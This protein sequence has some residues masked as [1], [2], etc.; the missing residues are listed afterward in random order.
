MSRCWLTIPE[1]QNSILKR[2]HLDINKMQGVK[3]SLTGVPCRV[4][5]RSST[6][7][8]CPSSAHSHR[9]LHPSSP[10]N[11][12]TFF[13]SFSPSLSSRPPQQQ[14]QKFL[15][16]IQNTRHGVWSSRPCILCASS[17]SSRKWRIHWRLY[18]VGTSSDLEDD[19]YM[20][21]SDFNVNSNGHTKI[22]DKDQFNQLRVILYPSSSDP[23]IKA[24]N[25]ANSVQEVFD[26]VERCGDQL[27]A[28]QASQA[29]VT[30][31]DLQKVYGRFG[32]DRDNIHGSMLTQFLEKIVSHP[33]FKKLITSLDRLCE[34]L[35]ST[36]VSC[37][38]LYL[39]KMGVKRNLPL[40]HKLE[41]VSVEGVSNF[42]MNAL[43]R[44]C[45][46]LKDS[47]IRGYYLQSKVMPIV[48]DRI[49]SCS[50]VEDLHLLTICLSSSRSLL[51]ESVIDQ[52]IALVEQ[53]LHENVFEDCD[54]K[55][56]LKIIKLLTVA[57]WSLKRKLLC[58]QLML[59]LVEK[60]H[61]LS[62]A[63]IW[64]LA[65]TYQS[66]LEPRQVL[67]KIKQYAL[68]AIGD[69]SSAI[70]KPQLLCLAPYTSPKLK[71]YFEGMVAEHLDRKDIHEYIVILFKTLRYIKTSNFRLCNAFWLKSMNAVELE[72]EKQPIHFLGLK[73]MMR[74]NLYHRYMYFNNNLG[75]SYR[76]YP[77]ENT[78]SKFLLKD[79]RM[80]TGLVP[81]KL[82]YMTSF[83]LSYSPKEGLPEDVIERV[84][85]CGPQFS[86]FDSLVLSRGIQITL[87]L[88]SF[89][90]RRKMQQI[91]AL[92]RMLDSSCEQHLKTANSLVD[93]TH[94]LRAYVSRGGSPRAF[95]FERILA[96]HLPFLSQL[97]SRHIRDLCFCLIN[98]RYSSP[99]ILNS[100]TQYVTEHKDYI[101]VTT[102]E[103]VLSC[104]YKLG[105]H[106]PE[107][108]RF[109]LACTSAFSEDGPQMTSLCILQMC[110]SLNMF[111]HLPSN[112]IHHVF[113]LSFID[114]LDE[115]LS[116]CSAK[117]SYPM[118]VRHL[119]MELNRA[120]CL[121]HPEE[122]I[123]WFHE[124]YCQE[125]L[126]SVAVPSSVFLT[127]VHQA[128]V[129]LVGDPE[130]LRANVHTPYYY[131]LDFE[132]LL[133][134]ESRPVPVREYV[135]GHNTAPHS[136]LPETQPGFRR[137]A[138]LV[139]NEE[140]YCVNGRQ[141]LGRH[142]M[143]RRH[144]E[145]LGY[146][147]VEVPH[148]HWYSM[149]LS[150]FTERLNYLKRLIYPTQT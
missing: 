51:T 92:C 123:P 57:E 82:A 54:P 29:V 83:L 46:Y 80:A 23:I 104:L 110:L 65:G 134:A 73:D 27:T 61:S 59:C 55:V 75:G 26:I 28:E 4:V 148:F 21:D 95:L 53:K 12:P 146:E 45:V 101:H 48:V 78:M 111:G 109:F 142:Q 135:S 124:K 49:S 10:V 63:Q 114:Q 15:S 77:F 90:K 103:L 20:S 69:S 116:K 40:I 39:N 8:I 5:R 14:S 128:L 119:L 67:Q 19:D 99:E 106:P 22:L 139:R 86:I 66:Y 68:N 44:L 74:R 85:L 31:W 35:D 122:N 121:D 138:V 118:Q 70:G 126:E 9:L 84:L 112:I 130:V 72:I 113:N 13:H 38:L 6:T 102:S 37:M 50:T 33:V 144:L 24:M 100:I 56:I 133:D 64:D 58:R 17:V 94:I 47:G 52:Y 62:I 42:N 97:N 43:S 108:E 150:T 96:A 98:A 32:F 81:S 36:A 89:L 34:N 143:E 25:E 136:H 137:V 79:I 41:E 30:L 125:L 147:V 88:N 127:E 3:W 76:N 87:A 71:N 60:I 105:H 93:M 145:L 140:D 2:R 149:S 131:L 11:T 91:T 117:S 1:I 115:E 18:S 132:F 16:G 107:S 141:L 129:Q 120:V 7:M